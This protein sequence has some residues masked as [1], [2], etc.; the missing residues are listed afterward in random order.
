[1]NPRDIPNEIWTLILQE[2][3]LQRRDLL[4]V[5]ASCRHFN[6]LVLP[7]LLFKSGTTPLDLAAGTVCI[8]SDMVPV[9]NVAIRL[10][11]ITRLTCTFDV[12]GDSRAPR[13]LRALKSLLV[14]S[15][16]HLRLNFVGDLLSA[17]KSD[18]VPLT[19]QRT[20]TEPFCNLLS[21]FP[22]D[23]D[24][25]VVFVGIEVFTCRAADIKDWL[26]DK[27]TFTDPN[28]RGLFGFLTGI[29]APRNPLRAKTL[30]THH[31]GITTAV[32]PL[33]S[34][35]SAHIQRVQQPLSAKYSSWTL[36]VLNAGSFNWPNA[37]RLS[38][39][40]ASEEWAAI[41]PFLTFANL[42]VVRMDPPDDLS[43]GSNIP[44][45]V[46][47]AFLARHS[48]ITRIYYYPDPQTLLD[49]PPFPF[50]ALPRLRGVTAA[51]RGM[52][53]LFYNPEASFPSLSIVRI[54]A[55]T[56][57]AREPHLMLDALRLLA[58]HGGSKKLIL[59]VSSGSWMDLDLGL[60]GAA[61]ACALRRVETV[62]LYGH[63]D[64]VGAEG[65]LSWIRLIPALRRVGLQDCLH[66][67]V[68]DDVKKH[69][70]S[71][72]REVLGNGVELMST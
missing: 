71:R 40:L 33:I 66:P 26:L 22:R 61:V 62:I 12:R 34:I 7:I 14:P 68:G 39:P 51:A 59:E 72:A 46:L 8:S 24:S 16:T 18:L 43:A 50:H 32:F 15:L 31:N 4:P 11:H 48:S 44:A 35:S 37:L 60:A 42:P 58:R 54:T 41:L 27:Y 19:P 38:A 10:P 6:D 2:P 25:P 9:L 1:M 57:D 52:H 45:P 29:R 67:D 65:I 49:A 47:D 17:Y 3:S 55:T 13:D 5:F 20:L 64:F 36:V 23:P 21:S 56:V 28:T 63:T 70:A 30:I 69:F 53:H